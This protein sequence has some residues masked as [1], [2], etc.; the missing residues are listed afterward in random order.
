MFVSGIYYRP[1]LNII[2]RVIK[3]PANK[4]II[5]VL[6]IDYTQP[7]SIYMIAWWHFPRYWSFV[8]G[9]HRSP[10]NS[11]HKGHW[12]GA[13]MFSLISV[14]IYGWVKQSWGWWFETPLRSLWRHCNEVG[15]FLDGTLTPLVSN[16]L[17]SSI[18]IISL[19]MAFVIIC[20]S[21]M[22]NHVSDLLDNGSRL[23]HIS[24]YDV[25]C[26]K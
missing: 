5:N 13:L 1:A 21:L 17:Y 10:M 11:P 19:P 15:R 16:W 22:N 8:R 24:C 6:I 20:H 23:Y 26:H 2:S 3:M 14:W 18:N 9:I 4:D 7:K 12:R 25:I